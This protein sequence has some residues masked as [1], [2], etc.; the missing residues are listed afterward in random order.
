MTI[1]F[2]IGIGIVGCLLVWHAL[3]W[4]WQHVADWQ[5]ARAERQH[6]AEEIEALL[7]DTRW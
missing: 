6:V 4:G 5:Q 1:T 2:W 3:R 7:R